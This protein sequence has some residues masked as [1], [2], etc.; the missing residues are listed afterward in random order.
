MFQNDCAIMVITS[1]ARINSWEAI[2]AVLP[3]N[4]FKAGE[5]RNCPQQ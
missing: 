2:F 4:H 5:Y 3:F 1:K